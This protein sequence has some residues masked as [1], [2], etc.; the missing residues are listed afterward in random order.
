MLISYE[1]QANLFNE[2]AP[3]RNERG[4]YRR[5]RSAS[6]SLDAIAFIMAEQDMQNVVP[7]RRL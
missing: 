5:D 1:N 2:A 6:P 4:Y 7:T 3:V